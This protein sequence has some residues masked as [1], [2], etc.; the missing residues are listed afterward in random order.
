[1]RL[2]EEILKFHRDFPVAHLSLY[3]TD[4]LGRIPGNTVLEERMVETRFIFMPSPSSR[5]VQTNMQKLSQK[6]NR[7]PACMNKELLT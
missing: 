2:P 5:G 7:R 3:A 6:C 1:M 4:L